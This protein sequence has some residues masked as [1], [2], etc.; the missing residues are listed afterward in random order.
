MNKSRFVDK[1]NSLS[2]KEQFLYSFVAYVIVYIFWYDVILNDVTGG[3]DIGSLIYLPHGMRYLLVL[4]F[5][6]LGLS[7]IHI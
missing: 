4:A 2:L 1:L 6:W 7:L 5:G 3:N